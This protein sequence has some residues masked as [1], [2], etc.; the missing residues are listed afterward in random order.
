ME[1]ELLDSRD[2]VYIVMRNGKVSTIVKDDYMELKLEHYKGNRIFYEFSDGVKIQETYDDN[3]FNC[4]YK[5]IVINVR[6]GNGLARLIKD[7]NESG[8]I[9]LFKEHYFTTHRTELL[10]KVIK[11]YGERV[12]KTPKGYVI[13]GIFMVD[14]KGTSFY[15][16]NRPTVD[17]NIWEFLCTVA[18]KGVRKVNIETEIGLLELDGTCMTILAKIGFFCNPNIE[19]RVFMNQLPDKIQKLLRDEYGGVKNE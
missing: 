14:N 9:E 18:Q 10:D 6:D 16:R 7:K 5:G 17:G 1:Y 19:D 3:V 11:S 4:Y 12:E 2:G 13:D 15:R 8:Y